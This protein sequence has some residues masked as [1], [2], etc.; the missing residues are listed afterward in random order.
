MNPYLLLFGLCALS[1]IAIPAPEDLALVVAGVQ[2]HEGTLALPAAALVA[3]V[4]IFLRDSL[5]FAVGHLVGERVL[6]HR[7]ALR[8]IGESRLDRARELVERRGSIAVLVGRGL[9]G[10]RS[11]A[12]LVAG[13][14]GVRPSAFVLWDVVGLVVTVPLVMGLGFGFGDQATLAVQWIV[15]HPAAVVAAAATVA[16]VWWGARQVAH[17]RCDQRTRSSI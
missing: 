10:F 1:G 2:V 11:A 4:A 7:I 8:V 9:V 12:F 14:M 17:A 15:E 13:A 6:S 16:V 5:F 3:G